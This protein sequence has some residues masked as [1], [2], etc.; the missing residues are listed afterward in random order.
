MSVAD[1]SRK[2]GVAE[3]MIY[4]WKEKYAGLEP[5]QVR[6]LKQLQEE[7]TK[8]KKLIAELSL[9]K[10]MLQDV[11]KKSWRGRASAARRCAI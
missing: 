11:V 7:N 8:L 10:A 5:S 6:E 9:D 4:R 2:L 1:L 3:Q